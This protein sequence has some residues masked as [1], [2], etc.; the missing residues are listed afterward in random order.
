MTKEKL[1]K[2][3]ENIKWELKLLEE[4]LSTNDPDD[5]DIAFINV[6]TIYRELEM[7]KALMYILE[8]GDE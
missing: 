1:A 3:I 5:L 2:R 4:N 7:V 8:E 6:E